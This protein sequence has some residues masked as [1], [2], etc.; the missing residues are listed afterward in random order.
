MIIAVI[1]ANGRSGKEFVKA[2]L[3]NGHSVRAGVHRSKLDFQH[4][5]LQQI[6]CD[7]TDPIQLEKLLDSSV[8]VVSL[9]G[10]V[11][12]SPANVQSETVK[13]LIATCEKLQ[14]SRIVSLTGTGVR[15]PGDNITVTDRLL[16]FSIKVIDPTRIA[17]GITHTELFLKSSLDW[18]II[19]VLKL[20]NGT[21]KPYKLSENGPTKV[22]IPRS[23]T[24]LACLE[25]LENKTFYRKAPIISRA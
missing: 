2:A 7:A 17:D 14:I 10:H 21:P 12:H 16:N 1:G 11:R 5:N 15:F 8:A 23:E 9:I 3:E 6:T 25:V 20:T 19:R 18:T 24:A 13:A 4:S 22:F